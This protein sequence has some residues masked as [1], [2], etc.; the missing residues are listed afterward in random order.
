M[1]ARPNVLNELYDIAVE[2]EGLLIACNGSRCFRNRARARR[3]LDAGDRCLGVR[4]RAQS[5]ICDLISTFV[6]AHAHVP[7]I[8]HTAE[9]VH[10]SA[11]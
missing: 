10:A 8:T 7:L 5:C 9:D 1:S 6:N 3:P 11:L 4:A 2:K